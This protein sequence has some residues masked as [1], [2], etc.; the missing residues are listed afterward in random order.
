MSNICLF[1]SCCW[2]TFCSGWWDF[3]P[4][5]G[6]W[7]NGTQGKN[8]TLGQTLNLSQG[9]IFLGV[10]TIPKVHILSKKTRQQAT[11]LISRIFWYF[12]NFREIPHFFFYIWD[13]SI[14]F[15]RTFWNL[16][17]LKI[18]F[19]QLLTFGEIWIFSHLFFNFR[20][21]PH[22][23]HLGNFNLILPHFLKLINCQLQFPALYDIWG[24]SIRISP[25]FFVKE[26]KIK[27]AG[28]F[29]IL[30]WTKIWVFNIVCGT[31]TQTYF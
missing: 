23:L 3:L 27:S 26:H 8:S 30:F 25:H 10:H 18:N 14:W 1:Q 5:L 29:P 12:R 31:S 24:I 11:F 28:K 22:F 20:D 4:H 16:W 13:I 21:I 17:T 6:V 2:T 19:P 7:A 9:S 15:S